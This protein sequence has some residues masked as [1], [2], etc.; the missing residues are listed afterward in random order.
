L[1]TSV[2]TLTKIARWNIFNN[3]VENVPVFVDL[4]HIT[5]ASTYP[6]TIG[7]DMLITVTD[8]LY[9]PNSIAVNKISGTSVSTTLTAWP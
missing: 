9:N 1:H 3:R 6:M 7:M 4:S 5:Q 2:P 8:Y